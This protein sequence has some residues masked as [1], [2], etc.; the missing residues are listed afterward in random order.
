MIA[1]TCHYS[2]PSND[3]STPLCD[4]IT[5]SEIP[6]DTRFCIFCYRLEN[7]SYSN[8]TVIL[9]LTYAAIRNLQSKYDGDS[10]TKVL[11]IDARAYCGCK[12]LGTNYSHYW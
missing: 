4:P 8:N 2:S 5:N 9:G 11:K 1:V 12:D 3:S 7:Y 6:R 10:L